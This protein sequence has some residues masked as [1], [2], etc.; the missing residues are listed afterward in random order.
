MTYLNHIAHEALA[1]GGQVLARVAGALVAV[2][3]LL[4]QA[5]DLVL[6]WI[7][8]LIQALLRPITNVVVGA[9][10][11]YVGTLWSDIEP[12][13]AEANA[14]QSLNAVQAG[15]F[16]SDIF[17]NLITVALLIGAIA[18]VALM[19]VEDLSLGAAFLSNLVVG[20]IVSAAFSSLVYLSGNLIPSAGLL[21]TGLVSSAWWVYNATGGGIHLM[22]AGSVTEF[23]TLVLGAFGAGLSVFQALHGDWNAGIQSLKALGTMWSS[24]GSEGLFLA[25]FQ[26]VSLALDIASIVVGAIGI[27]QELLGQEDEMASVIGI[28]LGI[29]GVAASALILSDKTSMSE[30]DDQVQRWTLAG[31]GS[32]VR[33][34]ERKSHFSGVMMRRTDS[35]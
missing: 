33:G 11:G 14:S 1:L 18:T 29:G 8:E 24:G 16:I 32:W 28:V 12:L 17:G 30:V 34:V 31:S 20:L 9:V 23:L 15:Q 25:L 2:G 22:I 26:T 13:W 19:V 27:L 4:L 7:I 3:K 5:F 10:L 21:T 35:N 6:K